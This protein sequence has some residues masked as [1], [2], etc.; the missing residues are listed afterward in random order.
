MIGNLFQIAASTLALAMAKSPDTKAF[1]TQMLLEHTELGEQIKLAAV[2]EGVVFSPRL[3]AD[4]LTKLDLLRMSAGVAFDISYMAEQLVLNSH[5][6]NLF[7]GYAVN[8]P[9]GALRSLAETV[10]P[11]L[12]GDVDWA[13]FVNGMI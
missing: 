5:Q 11:R 13:I 2:S 8:G 1:A 3:D 7:Q 9:S 6:A 12:Q 10:L 4:H